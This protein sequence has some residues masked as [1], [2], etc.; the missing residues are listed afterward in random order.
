MLS[1]MFAQDEQT[2]PV[3]Q[4]KDEV[5]GRLGQT[6]WL[7]NERLDA[8][9]AFISKAIHDL[10]E[11]LEDKIN[12]AMQSATQGRSDQADFA[13]KMKEALRV[14]SAKTES[15]YAELR[16]QLEALAKQVADQR[17]E[18]DAVPRYTS[19]MQQSFVQPPISRSS[20]EKMV[21]LEVQSALETKFHHVVQLDM[22]ALFTRLSKVEAELSR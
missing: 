10:Q 8:E 17:I 16:L 20:V 9:H 11:K 1:S 15:A 6:E 5:E 3:D 12:D 4:M 7:V 2:S 21:A 13:S 19:E 22:E 18:A 14:I